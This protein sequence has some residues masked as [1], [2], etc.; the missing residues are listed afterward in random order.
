MSKPIKNEYNPDT[1][2][3]PGET[4]KELLEDRKMSQAELAERM[5]RPKKTIN[6]I[7]KGKA[8]LTSDTAIQLE[9]VLGVP[10][11]FWIQREM[12]YRALVAQIEEDKRLLKHKNWLKH[13]P[14]KEMIKRKWIPDMGNNKLLQIKEMLNFFGIASPELWR[15]G[16]QDKKQLAFRHSRK[17]APKLGPT[18]VWIRKAEIEA[19]KIKC[20]AFD[21]DKLRSLLP[22]LRV[23]TL[24]EKFDNIVPNIIRICK[25]AGVAVV[26]LQGFDGVPVSGA[27]LWL[28]SNKAMVLLSSRYRTDDHLWFTFF[29]ELGHILLHSKKELFIEFD[30]SSLNLSKEEEEA[31]IFSA[32]HLIPEKDLKEW[33]ACETSKISRNAVVS[34]SQT[35]GISPGILVGRLQFM[36]KI[37]VTHM[38][39]LK[40]HYR[41]T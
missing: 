11:D 36:Q 23:L 8:S 34:F 38:N 33:L 25:G 35:L 5:G 14:I 32:N 12:N 29:H 13:F 7:I 22:E 39:N 24:E 37:P 41:W 18:S 9:R 17:L 31:N 4:L 26:F 20:E 3:V 21:E 28:N 16:W 2:S 40:K 19:D 10:A 6:E 1:I 30:R 15:V 27:S